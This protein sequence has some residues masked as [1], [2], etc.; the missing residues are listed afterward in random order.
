MAMEAKESSEWPGS[1]TYPTVFVLI[2]SFMDNR[3]EQNR[4]E[5]NIKIISL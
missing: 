5:K 4:T 2:V 3:I 1:T